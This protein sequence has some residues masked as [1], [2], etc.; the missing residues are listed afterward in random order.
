MKTS[1]LRQVIVALTIAVS[2]ATVHG[3]WFSS[4]GATGDASAVAEIR[5][6]QWDHY[7]QKWMATIIGPGETLRG[8]EG[9]IIELR[10]TAAGLPPTLSGINFDSLTVNDLAALGIPETAPANTL[11][12][13]ST[14][15]A[16]TAL[17]DAAYI[18][19][20]VSTLSH[21][22]TS[23]AVGHTGPWSGPSDPTPADLAALDI[24]GSVGVN[25]NVIVSTGTDSVSFSWD[26]SRWAKGDVFLGLN[27]SMY[28]VI[29]RDGNFKRFVA[30]ADLVDPAAQWLGENGEVLGPDYTLTTGCASNWQTGEIFATNFG[31][32]GPAVNVITRHPNSS[33]DARVQYSPKDR[34]LMTGIP[35]ADAPEN[36]YGIDNSPESVVF[37]SKLNMYVGNSFGSFSPAPASHLGKLFE[38]WGEYT[39]DI[40]GLPL[41]GW[42]DGE[43]WGWVVDENGDRLLLAGQGSSNFHERVYGVDV[44]ARLNYTAAGELI[45]AQPNR[46][47][48]LPD[49]PTDGVPTGYLS[50]PQTGLPMFNVTAP[51]TRIP[52]RWSL[53]KRLH[54]YNNTAAVG[55][56]SEYSST[57]RDAFWT[58]TGRQGTDWIDLDAAGKVMYY[59]SEDSF[60]HRY[61]VETGRQLPDVGAFDRDGNLQDS[62]L[63]AGDHRFHGLRI[64]PPGDGTGGFLV[65][66]GLRVYLVNQYGKIVQHYEVA[67]DPYLKTL[68]PN[69]GGV[70]WWYTLEVD[71]GGR[72][73][74]ASAHDTGWVYQFDIATGRELKRLHAVDYRPLRANGPNDGGRRVEGICV[75]WEYTAPQEVCFKADGVT[76]DGNDDDGDGFIDENCQRIEICS[77]LSPGDDDL[78][79][80]EDQYDSDCAAELPPVAIDDAYSMNQQD[81]AQAVLNVDAANGVLHRAPGAD[82]DRD[83]GAYADVNALKVVGVGLT[84]G[85]LTTLPGAS[86]TTAGNGTVVLQEDGSFVYTPDPAFHGVDTFSYKITDGYPAI[87]APREV[88]DD[89]HDDVATVTIT[90]APKVQSD[91]T[92]NVWVG[93]TISMGGLLAN[94]PAQPGAPSAGPVTIIE[95]GSSVGPVAFTGSRTFTTTQSNSVTVNAD[96]SF[97][98]TASNAAFG[99]LDYFTYAVTDTV[100][101]SWN[102]ATVTIN[103]M[104]PVVSVVVPDQIKVYDGTPL[105]TT[106]TVQSSRP[107]TPEYTFVYTGTIRGGA[108]YGPTTEAP[109]AVGSYTATCTHKDPALAPV[110][111]TGTITITPVPLTVTAADTTRVYLATNP[112]VTHT[113]TGF[114]NNETVSVLTGTTTC[115]TNVAQNANVGLYPDANTCSQ[116]LSATNYDISYVPGDLTITGFVLT[117]TAS[118]TEKNYGESNPPVTYTITGFQG[119]DNISVVNGTTSCGTVGGPNAGT[120]TGANTCSQTLSATNYSFVYVPG[121]LKINKV[122]L[123]VTA[124]TTTKVYGDANPP[125]TRAI[126]G[127]VNGDDAGDLGGSSVCSTA[128]SAGPNVGGYTGANT[129]TQNLTSLNYDISYV[130]GNFSITPRPLTATA[131]DKT[132]VL[133]SPLPTLDGTLTGVVVTGDVI[134]VTY[135]STN[136]GTVAGVFPDVLIPT[137]TAGGTTLL[138]NYTVTEIPGKLTVL[139][140]APCTGNDGYTTYSQGGWGSKPS[141]NNP[142]ALLARHFGTVYGGGPVVIGGTFTLTFSSASAVEKFLPA[143]GTSKPLTASAL[144]P[145]KSAAGNI[146]AQLLALR[147]ATDFSAA[148]ITKRGLG[149]LVMQS[150]PLAGRTVD[151]ILDLANAVV[152]GQPNALPSGLSI[153]GLSSILESLNMNYHEGT[154][155]EGLLS[156]SGGGTGPGDGGDPGDDDPGDD[157]PG[158]DEPGD[159]DPP[160]PVCA[161]RTQTQGGWG[162]SPSGSNPGA[163][164]A[165]NWFRLGSVTIGT[166]SSAKTFTSAKAVEDYLPTGG[167]NVLSGQVLALTLSVRFSNLG[168]TK[169]GLGNLKVKSGALAGHTVAQVLAWANAAIATGSAGGFSKNTLNN[170]VD[171]INNNFVDGTTDKGYLIVPS[172][173]AS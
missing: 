108:Q 76:P 111:D 62:K 157:D 148:G 139:S 31:E 154:V 57:A 120:Y 93:E 170:A 90:V 123:V 64:L 40:N 173:T 34:R 99:G 147:L 151:Q 114:V 160:A 92:F 85:S 30:T 132:I 43:D 159:D 9:A 45:L 50:D 94:D 134:N 37:D 13:N 56:P 128:A 3:A 131:N 104:R 69:S 155:N 169:A 95:A 88:P 14:A 70:A 124:S 105:P 15:A 146:A 79:G 10:S 126:T 102:I 106:C 75:M 82:Y 73:F 164:L 36:P 26:V 78:D 119:T 117:V 115:A 138:T 142:G 32:I 91:G 21:V 101:R 137:V 58:F 25:P 52:Y 86:L 12:F 28:K 84:E 54:R 55:A 19:L 109:T 4:T 68:G 135:T 51:S 140:M 5:L 107:G 87:G 129:C 77:A 16:P 7:Q 1:S 136:A 59:T 49:W 67:D 97:S 53:G 172:C 81:P 23:P 125:V 41:E 144:N 63:L 112:P 66:S 121:T 168:V 35:R 24:G 71:P 42:I 118:N 60:I 11:R 133:G 89:G 65:A 150:G 33:L 156:C 166:G 165:A 130:P 113:I 38:E 100:S 39:T 96:G 103:V 122:P 161:F 2:A 116:A 145:T 171:A 6:A 127:F 162:S 17:G 143:G 8:S 46:I 83:S 20:K 158:D 141:G 18:R 110:S 29:D 167:S 153:S 48:S 98:F 152:G 47:A 44:S 163:F 61:D 72:T 27:E 80:L 149:S 22:S 74:W